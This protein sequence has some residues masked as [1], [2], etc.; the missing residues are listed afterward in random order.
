MAY[1]TIPQAQVPPCKGVVSNV[2][3]RLGPGSRAAPGFS[4][5]SGIVTRQTGTD[6]ARKGTQ[7]TTGAYYPVTRI[8]TSVQARSL[9]RA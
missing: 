6:D 7:V 1:G 3:A 2:G 5:G 9:S 8:Q 4:P